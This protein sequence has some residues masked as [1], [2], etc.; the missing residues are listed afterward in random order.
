MM[1]RQAA[2]GPVKSLKQQYVH[3]KS[4]REEQHSIITIDMA[5]LIS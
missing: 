4:Q 2:Y 3:K 1:L 5:T